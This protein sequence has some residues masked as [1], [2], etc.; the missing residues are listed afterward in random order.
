MLCHCG[1]AGHCRIDWCF[2]SS[3]TWQSFRLYCTLHIP[4]PHFPLDCHF[5]GQFICFIIIKSKITKKIG[6]KSIFFPFLANKLW[7]KIKSW[8]IIIICW[9]GIFYWYKYFVCQFKTIWN[10]VKHV[11]PM[12]FCWFR[13]NFISISI[14]ILPILVIN[15]DSNISAFKFLTILSIF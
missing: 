11:L 8:L 14:N 6:K 1:L 15:I 7:N 4:F 10:K 13:W 5:I 9:A 3:R 2:V 12:F